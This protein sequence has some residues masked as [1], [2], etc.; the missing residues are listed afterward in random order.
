M[1][2]RSLT[3]AAC[4][5]AVLGLILVSAQAQP[6]ARA[7]NDKEKD[8]GQQRERG[9]EWR[10]EFLQRE[11]RG[12]DNEARERP[13]RPGRPEQSERP[14]RPERPERG[15]RGERPER[16]GPPMLDLQREIA[17]LESISSELLRSGQE[18]LASRVQS[19]ID[20]LKAKAERPGPPR[21]DMPPPPGPPAETP[22]E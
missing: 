7:N 14:E 2:I 22:Y 8:K 19:V 15:E 16:P 20:S 3:M 13:E 11:P 4:A 12:E 18:G 5:A 6:P 10:E 9:P 21:G 17:E 1:K